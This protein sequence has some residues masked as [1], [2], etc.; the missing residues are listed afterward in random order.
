MGDM[1]EEIVQVHDK[2]EGYDGYA[3]S[4]LL[5]THTFGDTSTPAEMADLYKI[6]LQPGDMLVAGSDGLWDNAFDSEIIACV[7]GAEDPQVGGTFAHRGGGHIIRE[8]G[9]ELPERVEDRWGPH[10]PW[11]RFIGKC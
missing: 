10:T 11:V 2:D 3:K 5:H 9:G 6:P 4:D 8:S 7:T 1:V